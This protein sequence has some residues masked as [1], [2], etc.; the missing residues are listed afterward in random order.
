MPVSFTHKNIVGAALI[1]FSA[2]A[3]SVSVLIATICFEEGVNSPTL[4]VLRFTTLLLILPILARARGVRL[5]L[6]PKHALA[7]ISIGVV[8]LAQT[9][10]YLSAVAYI[11]IGLAVLL[12]YL[13]PILTALLRAQIDRKIPHWC[14]ILAL[15]IAFFGLALAL[16]VSITQLDWRGVA[17]GLLAATSAA[18][19]LNASERI[20]AVLEPLQ[21]TFYTSLGAALVAVALIT[22]GFEWTWPDSTRGQLA[23]IA[24][25]LSFAVFYPAMIAGIERIGAVPTAILFNL[26]PPITIVLAAAFLHQS[27]T[28]QQHIGAGLVV[29]AVLVAQARLLFRCRNRAGTQ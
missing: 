28:G 21:T 10:G 6:P 13:Y 22:F 25:V 3:I 23:L 12:L 7:A 17:F 20:L 1:V 2:V 26:E 11:P 9:G 15:V 19:M 14:E 29:F 4:L 5:R 16:N 8:F 24:S 18:V 27:L